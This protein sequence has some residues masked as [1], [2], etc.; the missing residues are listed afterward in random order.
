MRSRHSAIFIP[1]AG[2]NT[3]LPSRTRDL[4]Y[5]ARSHTRGGKPCAHCEETRL[6]S[7]IHSTLYCGGCLGIPLQGH[8]HGTNYRL[9]C[10][11]CY[12]RTAKPSRYPPH[13]CGTFTT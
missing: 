10:P 4:K 2:R 13:G 1:L 5:S 12:G 11:G 6:C 3:V 8:P 9:T 7:S